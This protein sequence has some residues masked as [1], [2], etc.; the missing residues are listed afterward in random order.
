MEPPSQ[1]GFD[2]ALDQRHR[3]IA[4]FLRS[5]NAVSLK[6]IPRLSSTDAFAGI[7][8]VRITAT[9][10]CRMTETFSNFEKI[11]ERRAEAEVQLKLY[12]IFYRTGG[13]CMENVLARVDMN[14]V[15]EPDWASARP[16]CRR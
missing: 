14:F 8:N 16:N 12:H 15:Q 10:S 5:F 13:H 1:R 6:I 9:R 4:T 2:S 3:F 11:A 7:D